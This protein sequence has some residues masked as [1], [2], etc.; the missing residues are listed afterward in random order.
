MKN[1]LFLHSSSELYGSDK[2]LYNLVNNLDK[3]KY[4][5]TVMLPCNGPLVEKLKSVNKVNIVIKEVA[6]LRRKN[7]NLFG[8]F[9]YL[10]EFIKSIIFIRKI[11]KKYSIDI[12]Y[13]NTS[14]VF[15]GAVAARIMRK[16]NIWHVREIINSKFERKI[17]STIINVFSDIIIANSRATAH[18]ISNSDK[19]RVI[20]NAIESSSKFVDFKENK[21]DK[22]VIGMAGRINRWKGQKLFI[23]MAEYVI[24]KNENVEFLIAGSAYMGE[25]LLEEELK[26]YILEKGLD[27]K[28][29][30]LGQVD[31][32][33]IF[34]D[35][36]DIFVLPSIKPEPFGLVVIEA[37]D[38]AIPTIATNHGGPVEIIDNNVNGFL[39]DY[40][41]CKE[42]SEIV[43]KLL[44]DSKLR[45]NIALSGRK[46]RFKIFT[47]ENYVNNISEI[48]TTM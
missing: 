43:L 20:Y 37:M 12:V 11:I 34:Y 40:K 21:N 35:K 16:K 33:D 26:K 45:K 30:L 23:D 17:V 8:L 9:K 24:K 36:I 46:K 3:D 14:V 22:F 19:V 47:I 10:N 29:K 4:N 1:I 31:N 42:M 18:E 7:F 5:I 13:T 32:M 48:L 41:D 25:E 38:R 27:S 39:V 2:S 44:K 6:V 15:P 28:V